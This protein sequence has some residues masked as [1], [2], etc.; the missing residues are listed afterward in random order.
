MRVSDNGFC[1]RG[2][3]CQ[4]S[5]GDDAVVPPMLYANMIQ[6]APPFMPLYANSGPFM[7]NAPYDPHESRMEMGNSA[8]VL[9]SK[10]AL[11]S[12]TELPV[13]QDLTPQDPAEEAGKGEAF[14][15]PNGFTHN[16]GTPRRMQHQMHMV[17]PNVPTMFPEEMVNM[18]SMGVPVPTLNDNPSLGPNQN[19][20]PG[21]T[22]NQG[23]KGSFPGESHRFPPRDD[24]TLVVEKIP[25]DKLSLEAVNDWFKRF[26]IVT[27]VAI[28]ASSAKALVTFSNHSEAHAAW[29]SEEAIFGN[30]FVKVFWHRPLE[31]HGAIGQR[32][33]A[34]SAPLL[35]TLGT[36]TSSQPHPQESS[37]PIKTP[38]PKVSGT[39]GAAL[40]AR[41]RALEQQ[42]YQQKVLISRLSAAKTPA[43]KQELMASLKKL[44]SN[45]SPPFV[46]VSP[47]DPSP[48]NATAKSLSE[49]D[50]LDRE[51][52]L[53][54]GQV[55]PQ[56]QPSKEREKTAVLLERLSSLKAEVKSLL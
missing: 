46:S 33:L 45:H 32:A 35:K 26:G 15:Q 39:S 38:T 19:I 12:S 40:T 4:Y 47:T 37:L 21:A 28:D 11:V 27:N 23:A 44:Q 17:P 49:K 1:A 14:I 6:G 29:K 56:D 5:H 55:S 7:S 54:A 16:F 24:K 30:R 41:Q 22:Y 36:G 51:L 2:S 20:P 34:A 3:L 8:R 10:D 50:R 53:H 18:F 13:I 9:R 42:I 48:N 43:E 52:E 25:D 31:G